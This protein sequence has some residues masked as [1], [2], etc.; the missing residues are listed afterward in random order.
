MTILR[1]EIKVIESAEAL[2]QMI[3]KEEDAQRAKFLFL[4]LKIK[5]SASNALHFNLFGNSMSPGL[6]T[7]LLELY[8]REGLNKVLNELETSGVNGAVFSENV[9]VKE[10]FNIHLEQLTSYQD[11][12][13]LIEHETGLQ[14][15]FNDVYN[16]VINHFGI[17][18]HEIRKI[19]RQKPNALQV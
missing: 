14:L 2:K 4:L 10:L 8:S 5:I 12:A 11:V 7:E 17:P 6:V 15:R 9:N 3:R 16:L 13:T 1:K 19:Q 18:L